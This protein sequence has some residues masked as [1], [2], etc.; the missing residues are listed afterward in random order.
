MIGL[1]T[2]EEHL[3]PLHDV[4]LLLAKRRFTAGTAFYRLKFDPGH[5][6]GMTITILI[7]EIAAEISLFITHRT[8]A[9][10]YRITQFANMPVNHETNQ[11]DKR[12]IYF[13]SIG[14]PPDQLPYFLRDMEWKRPHEWSNYQ[15]ICNDGN[16]IYGD[17]LVFNK[18][19]HSFSAHC[20]PQPYTG[21][22]WQF[23]HLGL[24]S[25]QELRSLKFLAVMLVFL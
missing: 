3:M 8:E 10:D 5:G 21:F 20:S 23:I 25:F 11:L 7:K 1:I 4:A 12:P 18:F 15:G 19:M 17:V 6:F 13:E 2:V 14:V 22:A 24:L 9:I 16:S